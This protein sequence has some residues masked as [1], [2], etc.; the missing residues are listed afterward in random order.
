[1]YFAP[2][3]ATDGVHLPTY[4]D[5][6]DGLLASYRSIFGSEVNLEISSPDYQ[7]L[8][9]FARS[10]DDLSQLVLYDFVSRNPAYASG[11]ALD[12]LLPL[13]GLCRQGATYSSVVLTLSGMPGAVLSSAP[14]V[15]DDAGYIWSCP[16]AGISLN[17][18][19]TA[20][21]EAFCQTPGA[22]SAAVGAVHRLVSPVSGLASAINLVAATPGR[23][24]ESDAS[25]RHR[26]SLAAALPSLSTLD[27]LRSAVLS[28]PG[29]T[30][31]AIYENSTD[32]T[33]ENGIPSHSLCVVVSG[34]LTTDL[35][36]VIFSRKAPGIGTYGALSAEVTDAFGV[37]HTVRFQ[38]ATMTAVALSLELT[39]LS[40]FEESVVEKVRA[41]LVSYADNLGIGQDLVVPSLYALVYEAAGVSPPTFSISLL[42]ATSG[43]QSTG[44]ILSAAWNQRFTIPA[45]MIQILVK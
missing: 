31:C 34:G 9:L 8:S 23:E 20:T 37:S 36:P 25:C 7:L 16:S 45:N 17:E 30:S 27:S 13:H 14:Q 41:V 44:G 18:S 28:V 5:R 19:G 22:I 3:I 12:L 21:V 6:L 35:A 32:T 1:M 33:D 15:M 43:G 4:Q 10:L 42:T 26:L 29:V 11:E 38:R 2:Y 24:A 39:H 40:S